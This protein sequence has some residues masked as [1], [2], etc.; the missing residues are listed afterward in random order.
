MI[1][2]GTTHHGAACFDDGDPQPV[3]LSLTDA[4]KYD[5]VEVDTN[6]DADRQPKRP[7][8]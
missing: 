4:D 8:V 6:L 3:D 7:D 2:S 1:A 5:L